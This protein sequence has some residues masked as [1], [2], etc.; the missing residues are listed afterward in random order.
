MWAAHDIIPNSIC[1]SCWRR[2]KGIVNEFTLQARQCTLPI[3]HRSQV[4]YIIYCVPK[5]TTS[6]MILCSFIYRTSHFTL[7]KNATKPNPFEIIT[8]QTTRKENNWKTEEAL[9]RAAVT[10]ETERINPWCLWWL[11]LFIIFTTMAAI[12]GWCYSNIKGRTKVEAS[13]LS[14]SISQ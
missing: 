14:L 3:P 6:Y 13:P 4:Q 5:N 8:L 2:Y 7:A 12:I 1:A 10:L 11:L 9:A